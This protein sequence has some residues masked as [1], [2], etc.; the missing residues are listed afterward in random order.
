MRLTASFLPIWNGIHQARVTD[1]RPRRP[2]C[3]ILYTCQSF[4][5][6]GRRRI[7]LYN[8]KH[9]PLFS[10]HYCCYECLNCL[11]TFLFH[12]FI[13]HYTV[14]F[15]PSPSGTLGTKRLALAVLC[16]SAKR[17]SAFR[18]GWGWGRWYGLRGGQNIVLRRWL[19]DG[20]SR[21]ATWGE[22]TLARAEASCCFGQPL[23][24]LAGCLKSYCYKIKSLLHLPPD[25][26]PIR[27]QAPINRWHKPSA[28]RQCVSVKAIYLGG[29]KPY[30][31]YTPRRE[32]DPL[33]YHMGV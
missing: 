22:Q 4:E 17:V 12:V 29:R 3:K 23:A 28:M 10:K 5:Q 32:T 20:V 2:N 21:P 6:T 13:Q 33:Y 16:K 18:K 7:P 27:D 9:T 19:G 26:R 14:F 24:C 1:K 8:S 31:A 25:P 11:I 15:L 30:R